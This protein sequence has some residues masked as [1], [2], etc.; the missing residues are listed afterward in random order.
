MIYNSTIQKCDGDGKYISH[1]RST[2]Q[3]LDNDDRGKHGLGLWLKQNMTGTMMKE[4]KEK[5][6]QCHRTGVTATWTLGK[7]QM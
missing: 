5:I 6:K 7:M 3:R 4:A 1:R 2:A